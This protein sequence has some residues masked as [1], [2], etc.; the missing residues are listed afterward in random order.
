MKLFIGANAGTGYETAYALAAASPNDHVI[1]G[2][3]NQ[4]KGEKAL[5]GLQAREPKGTLSLVIFDVSDDD[6]IGAAAA[7]AFDTN[8]FGAMLFTNAMTPLLHASNS[9]KVVN[10]SSEL[11]S[12]NLKLDPANPFH[13]MPGEIYRLS[14]AAPDMLTACQHVSL[15]EVGGTAWAFCPGYVITDLAGDR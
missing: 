4:E 2:A 1:M 3:R 11:G 6:S 9:P 13:K 14:K 15:E 5:R 8:V 7:R 12:I 10:V